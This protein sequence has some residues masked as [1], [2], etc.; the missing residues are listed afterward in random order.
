MLTASH[1]WAQQKQD[2]EL[3]EERRLEREESKQWEKRLHNDT[4]ELRA[5]IDQLIKQQ[6]EERQ[7]FKQREEQQQR[8]INK[9]MDMIAQQLG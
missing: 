8:Q 9:F 5:Q 6:G 7:E 2:E 1:S 4:A 3:M